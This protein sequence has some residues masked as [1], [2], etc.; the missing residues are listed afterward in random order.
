MFKNFIVTF[1][2]IHEFE[3][4]L[5]LIDLGLIIYSSNYIDTSNMSTF[6]YFL[7]IV[8]G[9]IAIYMLLIGIIVIVISSLPEIK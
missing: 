2:Y 4:F 8:A 5:A 3:I 1:F 9:F 6:R 7:L